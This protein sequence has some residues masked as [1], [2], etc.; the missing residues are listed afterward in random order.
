MGFCYSTIVVNWHVCNFSNF[1]QP[2]KKASPVC[3]FFLFRL[4]RRDS[5]LL[6]EVTVPW[7]RRRAR[8]KLIFVKTGLYPCSWGIQCI[9]Y[10]YIY[11]YTCNDMRINGYYVVHSM[12]KACFLRSFNSGITTKRIYNKKDIHTQRWQF[13]SGPVANDP[14]KPCKSCV[15]VPSRNGL[16]ATWRPF[17]S[18][19]KADVAPVAFR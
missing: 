19:K 8:R 13:F 6:C 14:W 17:W 10:I 5:L 18:V 2:L 4:S 12:L 9:L 11:P 3:V 1:L 16:F 7:R 15:E